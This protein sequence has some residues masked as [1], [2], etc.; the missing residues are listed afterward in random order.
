M[1][2]GK[3]QETLRDFPVIKS[4]TATLGNLT[5][6][7]GKIGIAEDFSHFGRTIGNQESFGGGFIVAEQIDFLREVKRDP[8]GHRETVLG[9]LNRWG[10]EFVEFLLAETI[11]QLLPSIDGA[12]NGG[13]FDAVPG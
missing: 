7:P 1:A 10:Q 5:Q 9:N 11:E 8:F 13:G 3:R 6:G 12:G 2:R 4:I